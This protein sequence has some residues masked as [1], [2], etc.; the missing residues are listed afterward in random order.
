MNINAIL[1]NPSK[2]KILEIKTGYKFV[3]ISNTFAYSLLVCKHIVLSLIIAGVACNLLKYIFG[4]ARPK[5]F[6]LGNYERINF[7][8]IEHKVN[9]FP[10]GHTQA[11]FTIAMLCIL[12]FNRYVILI[13]IVATLMGISRIFMSMHFPSDIFF[14]A[15]LG[16]IFPVL[17][18][19]FFLKEQ[20]EGYKDK[21]L[22]NVGDFLKLIYW[23]IFI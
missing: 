14:G 15:Y 20:F 1:K 17:I 16:S 21:N 9:S 10:S 3:S 12:Y 22:M 8:N 5:Y 19:K 13:L 18:Y 6:F 11:A 2:L 7:F 23:R 4:V